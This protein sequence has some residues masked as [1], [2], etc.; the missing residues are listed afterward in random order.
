MADTG[1]AA[2]DFTASAVSLV[3]SFRLWRSGPPRLEREHTAGTVSRAVLISHLLPHRAGRASQSLRTDKGY[4]H[5]VSHS[6]TPRPPT[7]Q[8]A[9]TSYFACN[10]TELAAKT[11]RPNPRGLGAHIRVPT[12]TCKPTEV[13]EWQCGHAAGTG[14]AET[15]EEEG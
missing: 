7:H 4:T 1:P 11:E 14:T 15:R 5:S 13:S 2:V 12:Q 3:F 10:H 9:S 8:P 6:V